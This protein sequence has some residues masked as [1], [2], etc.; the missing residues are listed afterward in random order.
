MWRVQQP[1]KRVYSGQIILGPQPIS[2]IKNHK[3]FAD[4]A[5]F[6]SQV[7][8][9]QWKRDEY[10]HQNHFLIYVIE[11]EGIKQIKV[12]IKITKSIDHVYVD[13]AHVL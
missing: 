2:W 1:R 10:Q 3:S 9:G 12:L 8:Y 5:W 11:F 4:K 6:D 7:R 13:H